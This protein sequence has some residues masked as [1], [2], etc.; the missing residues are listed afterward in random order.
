M[1]DEGG[2]E[3]PARL[4]VMLN[5]PDGGVLPE[6][7]LREA[8]GRVMERASVPPDRTELSITFL[9]DGPIRE[10]NLRWL[11]HDWIPDVLSFPLGP[12]FLGD[13]YVGI[14]QAHRQAGEHGVP[15]DEEL[16]R[17]AVHGTLHLLGHDHPDDARGRAEAEMTR[18]QERVVR[19][20]FG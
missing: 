11:G 1:S 10:L 19:E 7:V 2:G 9:A 15:V 3:P 12:P 17:L 6:A 18:I 13:V 16:V 4:D 20:V 5:A 14:E 8:V